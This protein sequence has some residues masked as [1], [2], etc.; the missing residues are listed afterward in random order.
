MHCEV[1]IGGNSAVLFSAVARRKHTQI[2]RVENREYCE[3]MN[4]EITQKNINSGNYLKSL[5]FLSGFRF[6]IDCKTRCLL[7]ELI[8]LIGIYFE[9]EIQQNPSHTIFFFPKTIS[10]NSLP[11]FIL[12]NVLG[13]FVLITS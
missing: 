1:E 4:A 8:H 5:L 9:S 7:P 12:L 10:A 13:F 6:D 11:S 2:E 3:K